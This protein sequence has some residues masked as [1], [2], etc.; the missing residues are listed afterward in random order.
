VSSHIVVHHCFDPSD[1]DFSDKGLGFGRIFA[2]FCKLEC[3]CSKIIT[4]TER[5]LLIEQGRAFVVLKPGTLPAKR[6]TWKH[7]VEL[8]QIL[9]SDA[10]RTR[11][12]HALERYERAQDD[13][14]IAAGVEAEGELQCEKLIERHGI[15][16]HVFIRKIPRE[17]RSLTMWLIAFRG[18]RT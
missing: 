5:D 17:K 15:A 10:R 9:R 16:G 3:S 6:H 4:A 8:R 18:L 11:N 12:P 13:A 14:R 1:Y 2:G 7:V